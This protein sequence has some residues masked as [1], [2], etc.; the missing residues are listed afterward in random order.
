MTAM[1]GQVE[2]RGRFPGDMKL[3]S[4]GRTPYEFVML[5]EEKSSIS[6]FRM[7]PSSVMTLEPKYVFTELDREREKRYIYTVIIR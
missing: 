7:I 2:E 6:L 4:D 1:R 3:D 5:G